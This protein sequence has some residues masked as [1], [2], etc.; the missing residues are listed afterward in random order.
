MSCSSHS[1]PGIAHRAIQRMIAQQQFH[2]ALARLLDLV[3]VSDYNHAF[4]Y[5]RGAGSLQ[6]GHLLDFHQA[7]AARAL[8]RKIRV[9][10]KRRYFDAHSLAGFNQQGPSRG[11][12]L[13]AVDSKIHISHKFLRFSKRRRPAGCPEGVSPSALQ[14]ENTLRSAKTWRALPAHRAGRMPALR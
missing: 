2:H 6:L 5:D 12:D 7:H 8:Q 11:R 14:S 4:A 3:A 9:I 1:P 10:A 13:L